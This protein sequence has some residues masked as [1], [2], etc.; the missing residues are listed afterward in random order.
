MKVFDEYSTYYDLLYKDKNYKNEVNYVLKLLKEHFPNAKKILD[1]GCGT[2]IHANLLADA[3]YIVTG[4]D[5]SDKMILLANKKLENEFKRNSSRLNFMCGDVRSLKLNEK[6]DVVISLFHVFSYLS[7]NSDLK[8]AFK[9]I[10][11]SLIGGGGFLFDYWYGPGVLTDLPK[12][13]YKEFENDDFRVIRLVDPFI[14]NIDN[15]VDV[16]YSI[17]VINKQNGIVSN[18]HEV[19]KMR[20]FFVPEIKELAINY[21]QIFNYEW[22]SF[23]LPTIGSWNACSLMK[24]K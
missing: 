8:S 4:V 11:N 6:F 13:G 5:M 15:T 2:G 19:H 1:I 16:R 3:G 24:K 20:Y 9:S 17:N 10:N 7:D 23:E 12:R 14:N 18:I 21:S 22:L